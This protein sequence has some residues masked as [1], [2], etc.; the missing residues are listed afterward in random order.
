MW[1]WRVI[2]GG[3]VV[4]LLA[5]CGSAGQQ[6]SAGTP[7]AVPLTALP[8]V[9]TTTAAGSPATTTTSP[10]PTITTLDV[11]TTT[12]LPPVFQYDVSPVTAETVWASWREGCPLHFDQLSLLTLTYWDFDGSVATGPMVIN[13]AV[14]PD[15]VAAF[16]GL[17]DIGFPIERI[18]LVDAYDGDDKAA[19][20]ANVTSGFNCRYVDGTESWSNHAFGLAVDINPLLNPWA[21]EGNVL[22]LEGEPYTAREPALPGMINLGDEAVAI[23]EEVGWSWGG[24]WQS[25]DYMHFSRP[26]N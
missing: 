10:S 6:P 11:V 3:T 20:R 13:S 8:P 26:G 4:A 12:S 2:L 14:V 22:P 7:E 23:F 21:R 19:M 16:E 24:V 1:S 9:S 25:A 5:G 15:V 18:E 17:F